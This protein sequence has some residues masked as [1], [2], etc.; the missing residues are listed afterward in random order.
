MA[1]CAPA[2]NFPLR[3][4][5]PASLFV[6]PRLRQLDI[7]SA[8]PGPGR[9][10]GWLVMRVASSCRASVLALGFLPVL[11]AACSTAKEPLPMTAGTAVTG[12]L[13]GSNAAK[14]R[15]AAIPVSSRSVIGGIGGSRIGFSLGAEERLT[16]ANAEYRALEYG[17]SGAPVEWSDRGGSH[18]G[19][20]VP[21]KPYQQGS[22]YCRSF[23]HTVY[24]KNEPETAKGTACRE[25]DGTWK[26]VG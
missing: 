7:S 21:G 19:S 25:P 14:P 26:S 16:A 24:V 1:A 8:Y 20:I 9:G 12:S 10:P 2:W 15:K 18:H 17:Q 3:E 13:A 11:V 22:R 6:K 4:R 5:G 23:T